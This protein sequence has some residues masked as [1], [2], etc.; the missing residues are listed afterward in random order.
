MAPSF[1]VPYSIGALNCECFGP[2]IGV[3][4]QRVPLESSQLA[5]DPQIPA[6]AKFTSSLQSRGLR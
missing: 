2:Q 4:T 1:T 6:E 3:S 5:S